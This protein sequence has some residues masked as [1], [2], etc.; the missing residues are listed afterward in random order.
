MTYPILPIS[1][2][3]LFRLNSGPYNSFNCLGHFNHVYDD[4]DDDDGD[5]AVST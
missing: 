4:D 1:I 2:F 5:D 3:V